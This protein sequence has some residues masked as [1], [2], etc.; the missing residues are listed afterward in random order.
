MKI[1]FLCEGWSEFDSIVLLLRQF[2][3]HN[4]EFLKD[5][6]D[7]PSS[8]KVGIYRHNYKNVALIRREY[9]KLSRFLVDSYNYTKVFVWFDNENLLPVCEYARAQYAE[10]NTTHQNK[11]DLLIAVEMVEYWFLS[12]QEILNQMLRVTVDSSY[13]SSRGITDFLSV[14]N[15]D[16]LPGSKILDS[17]M[18]GTD[19]ANL[20]KP[21][22]ATRF[23]SLIKKDLVYRSD[24]LTR[25]ISKLD[26]T[27]SFLS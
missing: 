6:R 5:Y 25:F 8:G 14:V 1:A 18:K 21:K 19:I 22:R 11:I 24:S 13:V 4:Y 7:E 16:M 20:S 15:I 3:V 12:N 26:S 9:L 2:E 23:F 27:F 10:I 17:L